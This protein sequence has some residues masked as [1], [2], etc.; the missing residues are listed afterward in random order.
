M[1]PKSRYLAGVTVH[2]PSFQTPPTPPDPFEAQRWLE[3]RRRR[4]LLT[5]Q[6][7]TDLHNAMLKH[8]GETRRGAI[9]PVS[10]AKNPF[11]AICNELAVL[12]FSPPRVRHAVEGELPGFLCDRIEERQV[13]VQGAEGQLRT[14]LRRVPVGPGLLGRT[15]LWPRMRRIQAMVLGLREGLVR[16]DWQPEQGL[17]YRFAPPDTVVVEA[18]ADDPDRPVIVRELRWRPV[19]KKWQWV[20]E[21]Y[22]IS[23]ADAPSYSVFEATMS[24]KPGADLTEALIGKPMVG[25]AY[26]WRWTTGERAGRPFVP[27]ILYHA[28]A[29]GSVWNAWDWLELVEASLD[30][31]ALWTFWQH[32]VFQASWPQRWGV[33]VYVAGTKPEDTEAGPRSAVV[34]D[35]T[36][37]LHLEADPGVQNPQVGQWGSSANVLEL[38]Q[39]ISAFETAVVSSAGIDAANIVR[40][41]SGD[42][43]SGAALSISRDGKREA[44]SVYTPQ[45]QPRDLELIEKS[46]AIVNLAG[47]YPDPLPET[48]YRLDYTSIP[49]SPQELKNRREH[50]RELIAEGRMSIVEAYQAEHPGTTRSEAEA[51]LLRIREENER[52][53][54]KP[55]TKPA[56]PT[57]P[58]P[59]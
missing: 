12:Y 46:A 59:A 37:F 2:Q 5:G 51:H 40:S 16:V 15:G 33:G 58:D 38:Q 9:G 6:W 20:W 25:A 34:V 36:A 41:S 4:R 28:E 1:R 44:Q 39:A 13:P 55:P 54:S 3:T 53:K 48:G 22:D 52:F 43:W 32:C 45:F 56:L 50:H 42:A 29:T 14:A 19:N 21:V 49:L 23:N 31:S 35:P 17:T 11:S 24:G 47:A 26:P 30:I 7:Y 57:P 8:F 10:Q 18:T 27:W